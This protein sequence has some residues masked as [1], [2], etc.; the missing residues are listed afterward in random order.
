MKYLSLP[1]LLATCCVATHGQNSLPTE[2]PI[3]GTF[4]LPGSTPEPFAAEVWV[5]VRAESTGDT[6]RLPAFQLSPTA[7]AEKRVGSP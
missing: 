4:R 2:P 3:E 7:P 5:H 1:S 6:V